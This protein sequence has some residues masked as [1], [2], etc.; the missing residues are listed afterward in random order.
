MIASGVDG[1]SRGNYN[2]GISLGFD[3]CKFMPLNITAWEIAEMFWLNGAETG[4]ERI[5]H[6]RFHLRDGLILDTDLA[7]ISGPPLRRLC[8]SL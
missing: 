7:F 4:W 5:T 8:S 1:L 6:L 3:I 2:A